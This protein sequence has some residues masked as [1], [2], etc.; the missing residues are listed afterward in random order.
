MES[1]GD[2]LC[3][4]HASHDGEK[5]TVGVLSAMYGVTNRLVSAVDAAES[6]DT[7]TA[8]QVKDLLWEVHSS[9]ARELI[10]SKSTRD[11]VLQYIDKC[12]EEGVERPAEAISKA[13]RSS[14]GERNDVRHAINRARDMATSAGERLSTRL[15]A[16]HLESRG[17]DVSFM[18]SDRVIMTDGVPTSATP[19]MSATRQR[20]REH[21]KP[22]LDDGS[23]VL[24]T[25]F[26]GAGPDGVISTLGR[27]GSDLSATVMG[28]ALQAS[29][30]HLWKVECEKDDRGWMLGWQPGFEGVVHDQ[31]KKVVLRYLD[32]DE[33]TELAH[34]GKAVLHPAAMMPVVAR[35]IPVRIRN[36][37][38]P[39]HAG[40]I[41]GGTAFHESVYESSQSDSELADMLGAQ[42]HQPTTIT[43]ISNGQ[44]K[45]KWGKTW[46]CEGEMGWQP[47]ACSADSDKDCEALMGDDSIMIALIGKDILGEGGSRGQQL[48]S[49][50]VRIL[51]RHGIPSIVPRRVNGS[52]NNLT[53]VVGQAHG[54]LAQQILHEAL[55]VAGHSG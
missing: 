30:V 28:D 50:V 34:F 7:S 8:H 4:H 17:V 43:A 21:V 47:I 20:A 18:P 33:A 10:D 2:I 35:N 25:G 54:A 15:M 6:G 23:L 45:L 29:A 53:L 9:A 31:D 51:A 11:D 16:G 14:D 22:A 48:A 5:G 52:P 55:I 49:R 1:V 27:G 24:M 13:A 46:T 42:M 26:Y 19:N 3:E 12:L 40:T 41:I 36:T 39:D 38:N 37:L 44:Y 32:Y